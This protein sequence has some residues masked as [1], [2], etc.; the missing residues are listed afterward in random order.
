MEFLFKEARKAKRH[1]KASRFLDFVY[2]G[3]LPSRK[4]RITFGIK[5]PSVPSGATDLPRLLKKDGYSDSKILEQGELIFEILDAA[6][7]SNA[8]KVFHKL[9]ELVSRGLDRR[10][11]LGQIT[12]SLFVLEPKFMIVNK[13]TLKTYQLMSN[14][15]LGQQ[16]N[17]TTELTQYQQTLAEIT[18]FRENLANN[19]GFNEAL[20]SNWFNIFCGVCYKWKFKPQKNH[21]SYARQSDPEKRKIIEEKAMQ[22]VINEEKESENR[23]CIDMHLTESYD[24]KSIKQDGSDPRHIEVKGHGGINKTAELTWNEREFALEH[25]KTYWL[26]IVHNIDSGKPRLIKCKNP[27]K[28]MKVDKKTSHRFLLSG[29]C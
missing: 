18:T 12:P 8:R 29:I 5:L 11:K 1:N 22:F 3:L 23:K 27:L 7:R 25:P 28:R 16:S 19:F 15:V 10:I 4:R 17:L 20:D 21:Q 9:D 6:R 14:V 2:Y 13:R 24:L 26:Y